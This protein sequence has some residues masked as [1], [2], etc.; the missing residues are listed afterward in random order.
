M[1]AA[2]VVTGWFARSERDGHDYGCECPR[3][4]EPWQPLLTVTLQRL[5]E[6]SLSHDDGAS[7]GKGAGEETI[8]CPLLSP[9]LLL[10]ELEALVETSRDRSTLRHGWSRA[11]HLFPSVFWSLTWHTA[12]VGML[13]Q[14]LPQL[15]LRVLSISE[16]GESFVLW[17]PDGS[18]ERESDHD[19]DDLVERVASTS[20]GAVEEASDDGESHQRR[21]VVS[22][23]EVAP[24]ISFDGRYAAATL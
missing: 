20:L 14:L 17:H 22:M 4:N 9:V 12:P 6:G 23:V 11:R 3:R 24:S 2:E 7:C 19:N 21:R 13:E 5:R 10:R 1:G 18:S 8:E 16:R 15:E